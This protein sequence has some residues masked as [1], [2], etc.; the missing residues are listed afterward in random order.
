[1]T[2]L[3]KFANGFKY[4]AER[5][6]TTQV[7]N[8]SFFQ[9]IGLIFKHLFTELGMHLITL[10][11]KIMYFIVK[12]VMIVIDFIYTFVRQLVGINVDTNAGTEFLIDDDIIFKFLGGEYFVTV[13]KYMIGFCIV[14]LIVFTI[15]AIIKCEYDYTVYGKDNQKKQVF[16]KT[17]QAAFLMI[18]V[19]F[20]A[21]GSIIATN[22][23]LRTLSA[24]TSNN[25]TSSSITS[26][27]FLASS[28]RANMY[29]KYADNNKKIPITYNF[30][31][32]TAADNIAG[33]ETDGG[34]SE[35][36]DVVSEYLNMSIWT[37]GYKA[38]TMHYTKDYF[39]LDYIDNITYQAHQTPAGLANTEIISI[40]EGFYDKGIKTYTPEYYIMAEVI[41]K[42]IGSGIQIQF[43]TLEEM[44]KSCIS[45]GVSTPITIDA[46]GYYT[47]TLKYNF[48]G[49]DVPKSITYK[50]R[51]GA[52]DEADEAVFVCATTEFTEE[53]KSYYK[54]YYANE[55]DGYR[56]E[57][58]PLVTI[59]RGTFTQEDG[60]PTAIRKRNGVV[61]CYRENLNIPTLMDFFPTISYEK[62]EG[63]TEDLGTWILRTG[64]ELITGVNPDELIPYV[65]YNFDIFSLFSKTTNVI[66][67]FEDG[68][69][70]IDYYFSDTDITMQNLYWLPNLDLF[71]LI[72]GVGTVLLVMMKA[73]FGLVGRIFDIIVLIIIYPA[74]LALFPIK[75]NKTFSSWSSN[76]VAKLTGAYGI[77]ISLNLMFIFASSLEGF[78]MLNATDWAATTN[79]IA[80]VFPVAF[81]NSI[82]RV[83]FML[84]AFSLIQTFPKFINSLI[85]G[86]KVDEAE[87]IIDRGAQA[88]NEMKKPFEWFGKAVSGQ[89]AIDAVKGAADIALKSVPGGAIVARKIQDVKDK[90]EELKA[91][92]DKLEVSSAE[93]DVNVPKPKTEDNN[94]DEKDPVTDTPE[95]APPGTEAPKDVPEEE[96]EE[97]PEE[98]PPAEDVPEDVPLP[99][100]IPI[101][102]PIMKEV[103]KQ[104]AED[105]QEMF[106]DV[107]DEKVEDFDTGD[108][109]LN[110]HFEG[111]TYNDIDRE[112][113]M[114]K[115]PVGV[116]QRQATQDV[117]GKNAKNSN[118]IKEVSD[119]WETHKKKNNVVITP[120]GTSGNG[121]K[122]ET[123]ALKIDMAQA[124]NAS[125][126]DMRKS[127]H[128]ATDEKGHHIARTNT[129]KA[130]E[131]ISQVVA[132][133]PK[134]SEVKE[135]E[136]KT[137]TS[138]EKKPIEEHKE[139]NSI[140]KSDTNAYEDDLADV[141]WLYQLWDRSNG[142]DPNDT[143]AMFPED[144]Y[145]YALNKVL[146]RK[147]V[148]KGDANYEEEYKKLNDRY[149]SKN[150]T[151]V[152]VGQAR[153]AL[154][155]KYGKKYEDVTIE[156]ARE[157]QNMRK[158]LR[159]AAMDK[160]AKEENQKNHEQLA[161]KHNE[162][163]KKQ[164]FGD[165]NPQDTA[166]KEKLK[167]Y[168]SL[169]M[170]KTSGLANN[171]AKSQAENE[172]KARLSYLK[173]NGFDLTK[174]SKES[175]AENK[176]K[177]K[178][179]MQKF[180]KGDI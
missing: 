68:G 142:N 170:N 87:D 107:S 137:P 48:D 81:A 43:V 100:P 38:F 171:Q 103:Q 45:A 122:K 152:S 135:S 168:E 60:Y 49:E 80:R 33:W 84:V 113:E 30:E 6:F 86:R 82:L 110:K 17:L 83:L 112:I 93:Q 162:N 73:M 35:I 143:S 116:N 114:F 50:N 8:P 11:M 147:G 29:R 148:K 97:K 104:D 69:M 134:S 28:Y 55:A 108:E 52:T 67:K 91:F 15:I 154:V 180:K 18:L 85:T 167:T 9:T 101:P 173:L 51:P 117:L 166:N 58:S 65:Y 59:A 141:S 102:K 115:N 125:T 119:K 1:M 44:Y 139:S 150:W 3:L 96:P 32:P 4:L 16:V 156:D 138:T 131:K 160:Q 92:I 26:Q 64:F 130:L 56:A 20:I 34:I 37:R 2:G 145:D 14:L 144:A 23:L 123:V 109:E 42:S 172:K 106:K 161:K 99:T 128:K 124:A 53:G 10:F 129:D 72:F 40:Y 24:A 71:I 127:L 41:D 76:F 75:G 12:W 77:I 78:A 178:E 140:K 62:P 153:E 27:I 174:M 179:L 136:N 132:E 46:D 165:S 151:Y 22:A 88:V 157:Y 19:P 177:I 63:V 70:E 126:S 54:A 7:D 21:I 118:Y 66:T 36:N 111:K 25:T 5:T 57:G 31:E 159:Y 98:A 164:M 105:S 158:S 155:N 163:L 175:Q 90:K 74:T 79:P 94:E 176:E 61:E 133:A 121:K 13:M 39:S 169:K 120:S 95:E 149:H 47:I 146:N 89:L